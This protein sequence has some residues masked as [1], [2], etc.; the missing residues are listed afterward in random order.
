VRVLDSLLGKH[1]RAQVLIF[2]ELF[3]RRV[4]RIDGRLMERVVGFL[5][6]PED[7]SR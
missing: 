4:Q 1:V 2:K 3:F 6:R 5:L 7:F